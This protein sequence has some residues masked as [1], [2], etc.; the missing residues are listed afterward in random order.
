[1]RFGGNSLQF[2]TE[3]QVQGD[4]LGKPPVILHKPRVQ[5]LGHVANRIASQKARAIGC[6]SQET[7]QRS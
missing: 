2:I 5:P 7:F 6:A 3:S 4:A 1:M